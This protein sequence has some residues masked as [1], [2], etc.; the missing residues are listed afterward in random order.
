VAKNKQIPKTLLKI[1]FPKEGSKILE[2]ALVNVNNNIE[3]KTL[4]RISN[5][6]A[7]DRLAM[8]DHGIVHFQLVT[9]IAL[10]LARLLTKNKVVLSVTKNYDLNSEYGELVIFLGSVMHDLGISI[11]RTDHEEYSLFLANRLLHEVVDFLPVKERTIVISETLHAIIG[12][13]KGG[14]PHTIEA[15][16]LRVADALDMTKGRSRVTHKAGSVDIHSIS[17]SSIDEIII[18]EGKTRPIQ[19]IINLNNSAGVFQID[20]LLKGKLKGSGIE[21]YVEIKA[22]IKRGS[23]KNLVKDFTIKI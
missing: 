9:N 18:S 11:S 4:W 1:S 17:H 8:T 16:I 15:G 13:R 12:H 3:L 19:I 6:N 23:E 5:V 7:V 2:K 14:T 22:H 21:K 20:E 10:R